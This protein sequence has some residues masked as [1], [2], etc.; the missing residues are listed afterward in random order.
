METRANYVAVGFFTLVVLLA[1]FGFIY[2]VSEYDQGA[3]LRPVTV[4]IEGAVTGLAPGSEVHFNG[5]KVGKV[6]R[7]IF[8]PKDPRV[9]YAYS[10]I[11]DTTPVRTDTKAV[12]GSQGLT[13]IAYISLEGGSPDAASLFDAA[14]PGT[15]PIIN[16]QPSAVQDILET[17]RDV[18]VKANKALESVQE[19]VEENRQP[20]SNAVR[21]VEKFTQALEKNSEGVDKFL[22][23]AGQIGEALDGFGEKIDGTVK[24]LEK[25]V[26]AVD[27]EKVKTTVDNVSVFS[28]DLKDTGARFDGFMTEAGKATE[29]LNAS[30][31]KVDRILAEVDEGRVR[32]TVDNIAEAS[33]TAKTVVA[34]AQEVT[35]TL[36]GRKQEID[37]TVRDASEMMARLNESS[38]KI[39]GVLAKLDGF[40]GN[41]DAGSVMTDL[42]DTLGD[43]RT[44]AQN[45]NNKVDT[46]SG[47]LE[48][49]S[50][51]GL[52]DFRGLINDARRSVNRIESVVEN[53]ERNPSS[54]ISGNGRTV[55][56]YD[57][58]PRR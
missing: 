3:T 26:S 28:Q 41:G 34:N 5:I 40:L 21:N 14:G 35:Q 37:Q 42:R 15:A 29:S 51:G 48:S 8:D 58:R 39:D 17:V 11:D 52:S 25:I 18:A 45:L 44:L 27:P 9:V 6:D 53:I 49:F 30:L 55:K 31:A 7:L 19:F 38:K 1:S 10:Q 32:T 47:G 50:K 33:E 13:G 23:S 43:F 54:L 22:A 2:W 24:G 46:I 36:A 4:R 20:V 57:G 56:T 16:A 12:I